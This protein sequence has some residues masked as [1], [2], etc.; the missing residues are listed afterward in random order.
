MGEHWL[1]LGMAVIIVAL[2][3]YGRRLSRVERIIEYAVHEITKDDG[4]Q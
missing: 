1:T 4:T 2:A 3:I